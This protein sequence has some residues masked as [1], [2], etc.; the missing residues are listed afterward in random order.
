MLPDLNVC[1]K[2]DAGEV[3]VYWEEYSERDISISSNKHFCPTY[4]K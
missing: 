4:D 2:E 3:C 1:N